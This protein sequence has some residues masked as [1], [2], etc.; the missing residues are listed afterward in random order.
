MVTNLS[1]QQLEI[2][3]ILKEYKDTPV[4]IDEFT[5]KD[6]LNI[7]GYTERISELRKKGYSVVNTSRN[8]YQLIE[9]PAPTLSE[10][11]FIWTQARKR[12]YT[13][14]MQR[15]EEKAKDINFTK[16]VEQALT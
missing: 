14:L 6:K 16:N 15:C 1:R 13:K 10:L 11:K 9:E 8:F 5:E 7:R 2:Y 3:L 12:G 4:H